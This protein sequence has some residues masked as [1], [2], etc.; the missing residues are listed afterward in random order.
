VAAGPEP[1]TLVP[2]VAEGRLVGGNLAILAS[3]CGTRHAPRASGAI[4]FVEDVGEPPYRVDRMLLQLERSGAFAGLAGLAFG[5]FT[6]EGEEVCDVDDVLAEYAER[7]SVPAVSG[8]PFGHVPE[9]F[10]LPVGSRARLDADMSTL[11]LL[12]AAVRA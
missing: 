3:L 4:L 1:R 12:E 2:G 5:R 10:V 8:L 11:T 6:A 7:A 9:N